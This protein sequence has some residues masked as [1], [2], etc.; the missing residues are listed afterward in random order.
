MV[1]ATRFEHFSN[2][3]LL[4]FDGDCA[5]CTSAV[6]RLET[7]LPRFPRAMPWQ[8]L[9]L[10]EY[11]LSHEDVARFVWVVTPSHQYAGHLALSAL[12]RM[13]RT[14]PWRLAGWLLATPPFSWAAAIGYRLIAA[15]RHRLPGGTPACAVPRS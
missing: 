3:P 9:D 4:V 12:L 13:Q 8:W 2:A 7:V 10:D 1:T 5:F 6:H 15:N 11:G 14:F